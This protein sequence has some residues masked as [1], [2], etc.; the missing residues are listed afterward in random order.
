MTNTPPPTLASASSTIQ[1]GQDNKTI[2]VLNRGTGATN[3]S[4][5]VI[6][7]KD[8]FG[9]DTNVTLAEV[10]NLGKE[11]ESV[12]VSADQTTAYVSEGTGNQVFVVSNLTTPANISVNSVAVGSEPRGTALS[13]SGNQLYVAQFSDGTLSVINTTSLAVSTLN[14]TYGNTSLQHPYAVLVTTDGTGTDTNSSVFV[15][16]FY[17]QPAPAAVNPDGVAGSPNSTVDQIETFDTGKVGVVGVLS[18]Y[19]NTMTNTISLNPMLTGFTDNRTAL[20]AGVAAFPTYAAAAGVNA[21]AHPTFAYFNQLYSLAQDPATKKIYVNSISASPEP[22][23]NFNAN[24]QALVGVIDPVN[25]FLANQSLNLNAK[26]KVENGGVSPTA[27]FNAT[28]EFVREFAGDTV[29]TAISNGTVVFVSRS[30]SHALIGNVDSTGNVSLNSSTN[31]IATRV[32]TGSIPNGVAVDAYGT[33]AYVNSEV[34]MTVT[35]INLATNTTVS[36]DFSGTNTSLPAVNTTAHNALIG[37]LV[38]FT[39]LGAGPLNLTG[40][41][42][43]SIDTHPLRDLAS[44]DNWSSCASCHAAGLSDGVTWS[45]PDGPRQTIPLDGTFSKVSSN[46]RILNWS[47]TRSSVTDFNQNSIKVQ[48]GVGFAVN[49]STTV[50]YD[51]GPGAAAGLSDALD[52]ETLWIQKAVRTF[53]HPSTLNQAS[54]TAGNVAFQALACNQCHNGDQWTSSQVNWSLPLFT[55]SPAASGTVIGSAEVNGTVSPG[56]SA[57]TGFTALEVP[58]GVIAFFTPTGGNLTSITNQFTGISSDVA[59]G[60]S[61]TLDLSGNQTTELKGLGAVGNLS[62]APPAS[63][64]V[65][66]LLGLANSAPYGHNGRAQTLAAVFNT[67]AQGGLGHPTNGATP[68]Q[69]QDLVNYLLS[70][71]SKTTHF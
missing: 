64:N 30:G 12:S 22:P 14:L 28:T 17:A 9:N 67:T 19:T 34:A 31:T 56:I 1:M 36:P 42:I 6:Q 24:V 69:I 54:V 57:L 44:A 53:N 61:P 45:F 62:D 10:P 47:A 7:V 41:N 32:P 15:S 11:P 26:I 49:N 59:P 4:L 40:S 66:S 8:S 23:V 20:A 25:G 38:F 71:D 58:N 5:D 29:A 51:H 35:P 16:D 18:A 21:S 13:P 68:Q 65:P 39:G 43:R 33:R 63:F 48:G 60:Y 46:Q 27:P 37:K 3:G 52:L 55:A 70:I 50:F 2:Y